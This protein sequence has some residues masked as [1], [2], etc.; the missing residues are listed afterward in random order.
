MSDV[1]T[2]SEVKALRPVLKCLTGDYYCY[3]TRA[4][5]TG[6]EDYCRICLVE[7]QDGAKV[8]VD[9]VHII[10]ECLG[11][12][13]I[14]EELM[15]NIASAASTTEVSVDF[16]HI[17]SDKKILT[18]FLLDNTSLNLPNNC[19]VN[20]SDSASMEI[21]RQARRLI[22]AVHTER[23]RKLKEVEKSMCH[24]VADLCT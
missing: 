12:K 19:R 18:Q 10:S 8:T 13:K 24:Y 5:L 11:T 9:I 22:S 2:S 4:A 15:A 7:G 16:Q 14:R 21:F 23:L 6:G 1:I 3:S 20:I 17:V